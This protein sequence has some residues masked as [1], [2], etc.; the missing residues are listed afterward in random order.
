MY[1]I[2]VIPCLKTNNKYYIQFTI[3]HLEKRQKNLFSIQNYL[4]LEYQ[5]L[6]LVYDN[7]DVGDDHDDDEDADDEEEQHQHSKVVQN[8][9]HN[10][11]HNSGT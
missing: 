11:Y 6:L 1:S 9:H 7:T 5:K 2:H 10:Y 3:N 8:G 4:Y